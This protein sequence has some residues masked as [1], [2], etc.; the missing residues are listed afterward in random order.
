MCEL[1][2][3]L[4]KENG[5]FKFKDIEDY[6]NEYMKYLYGIKEINAYIFIF[7]ESYRNLLIRK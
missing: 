7:K 4:V 1:G 5:T 6:G 3:I 2:K